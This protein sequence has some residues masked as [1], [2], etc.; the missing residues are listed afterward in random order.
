M[1]QK[2]DKAETVFHIPTLDA[3]GVSHFHT[4][5]TDITLASIPSASGPS[6]VD[7]TVTEP[8][9]MPM[10]PLSTTSAS[11]QY[12]SPITIA[13]HLPNSPRPLP[14]TPSPSTQGSTSP[15][16]ELLKGRRVANSAQ[17]RDW[18]LVDSARA[19]SG[20]STASRRAAPPLR[21]A[22]TEVGRDIIIQHRD[23]GVVEELPPPYRNSGYLPA[24]G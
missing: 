22:V 24:R 5:S 12:S 23:G 7:A 14:S 21:S 20:N 4:S 13:A 6:S 11:V 1:G 9:T 2:T 18:R 10:S 8:Q 15:S 19:G 17:D 16:D 3:R